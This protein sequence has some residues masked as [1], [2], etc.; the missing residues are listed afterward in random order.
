MSYNFKFKGYDL[1]KDFGCY[2]IDRVITTPSKKKIFDGVPFIN[3]IGYDFST[4]GSNGEDVYDERTVTY[5]IAVPEISEDRLQALKSELDEWLLTGKGPLNTEDMSDVY[6]EAEV[7]NGYSFNQLLEIGSFEVIFHCQP[8]K[9]GV[10]LEGTENIP[11]DTYCFETDYLA[12]TQ[13]NVNGT[14]TITLY[15]SGRSVTPTINCS[16]NMSLTIE[17]YT[18]NLKTGDN[19]DWRIRLKPG[20]NIV[21]V[22]GN[23]AIKFNWRKEVL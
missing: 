16:S 7:I 20:E 13:F 19:K 4:I 21:Q 2:A 12:P 15:N 1:E 23:G 17:S 8:F 3:G 6:F 9:K 22:T 14:E 18:A 11:W 10:N 5:I